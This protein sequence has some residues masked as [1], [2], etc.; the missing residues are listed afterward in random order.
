MKNLSRISE[1]LILYGTLTECPGLVHGKTGIA[2][3]FF[4]YAQ[5]VNNMLFA[6]YAMDLIAEIQNQ[7]HVNSPVDYEKGIAG[8]GTGIIYLIQNKF[9]ISEDD[10]CKDFDNRMVR[11]VMYEPWQNFSLYDG[12]TGYFYFYRIIRCKDSCLF[13]NFITFSKKLKIFKEGYG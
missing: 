12:L 6:D 10:I 3:F 7:I 13:M 11:A 2:I 1:M 8:I 5:H 9:L 4:H